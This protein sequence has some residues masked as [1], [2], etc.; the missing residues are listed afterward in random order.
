MRERLKLALLGITL[1]VVTLLGLKLTT[2]RASTSLSLRGADS[3][4][5]SIGKR[6]RDAGKSELAIRAR[7]DVHTGFLRWLNS[8]GTEY[9][10]PVVKQGR[11]FVIVCPESLPRRRVIE[12]TSH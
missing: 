3:E 11:K 12:I 6:T 2:K 7:T 1:R 4:T 5:T 9:L 10:V 8:Q